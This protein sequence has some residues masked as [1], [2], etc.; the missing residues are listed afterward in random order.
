MKSVQPGAAPPWDSL[1]NLTV[2]IGNPTGRTDFNS[3]QTGSQPQ[4]PQTVARL[5]PVLNSLATETVTLS[6]DFTTIYDAVVGNIPEDAAQ[7]VASLSFRRGDTDGNGNVTVFDAL[8]IAQ[9]L[10]NLKTASQLGVLNAA[11][12]NH[13]GAAGDKITIVDALFIAQYK[14]LLKNADYTP[15]Q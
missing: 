1:S 14:A 3:S 5:V 9:Y 4:P 11:S 8:L 10:A 2:V 12:V 7:P 6:V 15:R 13:D